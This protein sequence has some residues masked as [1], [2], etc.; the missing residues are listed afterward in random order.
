MKAKIYKSVPRGCVRVPPSKSIAHRLIFSALLSEGESV[1]ENVPEC[2]D[3]LATLDAA[4]ALGAEVEKC[5]TAYN[6]KGIGKKKRETGTALFVNESGSTLRFLIPILLYLGGEYE[7]LARGRLLSRPLSVYEELFPGALKIEGDRLFVSGRIS[8]GEYEVRADLSSQFISGLLFTLPLCDGDS[9]II[10]KDKIESRSYIDLTLSC[11]REFGV[12]AEWTGENEI[13]I[14][15]NQV[16]TAK[17]VF[18][19]GDFSAGIFIEALNLIHGGGIRVLGLSEKSLQG[20]RV[21]RDIFPLL[22]NGGACIDIG[23]CPDNAPMLFALCALLSGGVFSGTA[24]LKIKESDR[25][26]AMREELSKLGAFLSI[27][28]DTVTVEKRTLRAPTE[29]ISSHGDHRIAMAMAVLLTR[30]GGEITGAEAVS[31]SYPGF[32]SDLLS[33]GIKIEIREE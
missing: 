17:R 30:F 14:P 22:K 29:P 8:G 31:K 19:E 11:M 23:D 26:E 27:D 15:K 21:Y 9:K 32:F 12:F 16:Y 18:V 10:L 33:L 24:R 25:A 3:V 7:I 20:D 6:I 28:G 1:I 4:R 2:L 13:F 5:G